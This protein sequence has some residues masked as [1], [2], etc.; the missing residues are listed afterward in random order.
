MLHPHL[1]QT[2][3]EQGRST[4]LDILEQERRPTRHS[5]LSHTRETFLVVGIAHQGDNDVLAAG[6]LHQALL[7]L[8]QDRD[9]VKGQLPIKDDL[10][11]VFVDDEPLL[12]GLDKRHGLLQLGTFAHLR[13]LAVQRSVV[14]EAALAQHVADEVDVLVL[15][16]GEALGHKDGDLLRFS[17]VERRALALGYLLGSLCFGA[18]DVAARALDVFPHRGQGRVRRRDFGPQRVLDR[19]VFVQNLKPHVLGPVGRDGGD[20]EGLQLDVAED[21]R[22]GHGRTAREACFTVEVS[23]GLEVV[24]G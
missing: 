1:R 18:G 17:G 8:G 21:E 20:E 12:Q 5:M 19:G 3:R 22:S 7:H 23:R 16:G 14:V 24:Q 4:L 6:G 15:P 2:R 11:S 9:L 10:G 13:H